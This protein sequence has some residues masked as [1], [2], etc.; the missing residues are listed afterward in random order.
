ML[1]REG[2]TTTGSAG[3]VVAHPALVESRQQRLVLV[4]LIALLDFGTDV[5]EESLAS[6]RGAHAANARWTRQDRIRAQRKAISER[7]T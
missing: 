7:G 3:Q 1:A 4:R 2:M 6:R 5:G